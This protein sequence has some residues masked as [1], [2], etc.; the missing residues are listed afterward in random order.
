M[1][2]V[3]QRNKK[4]RVEEYAYYDAEGKPM[5]NDYGF[6]KI[7]LAYDANGNVIEERFYGL[8]GEPVTKVVRCER[9]AY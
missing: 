4:G 8:C 3:G 1:K 5:L 7:T 6:A 2:T 9:S